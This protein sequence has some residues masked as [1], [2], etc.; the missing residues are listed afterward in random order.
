METDSFPIVGVGASAGGLEALRSMFSGNSEQCGMAFVV[1]QHLDPTHESLMAQL[2]ERYTDMTVTQASG[3]ER[4]EPDHI[5]V[6]PPGHGL[7]LN[8]GILNLTEFTEQRGMRRPI[9]DFFESLARDRHTNA[10][11]VILSGTGAD[12]SRG[13]RAIKEHGGLAIAQ[14][15]DSAA[16]DGMPSSAIS[17]GLVDIV[18][19]PADIIKALDNFFSRASTTDGFVQGSDEVA[20]NLESLCD[21]LRDNTGHDLSR[22]K[23]NTL[24]RRVARRMQL[25]GLESAREYVSRLQDDDSEC[26]AL[27]SDLLINVTRFFRDPQQFETLRK[28]VIEPLVARSTSK[29]EIRVWVPGCSSGEEAYSMAMMFADEARK[30][31]KNPFIQIFATDID[32]KMLELARAATYPLSSLDDIPS[33]M[34]DA[35]IIG[36][37]DKFTIAPAIRDMVRISEHNLV[38]DPPF[39]K[40]DLVSCRNVLIY[41][42]DSLQRSVIPLFHFALTE[43]GRLFLGSSETIGRFEDLFET[44]D[45]SARIFRRKSVQGKY[46][47]QLSSGL[48]NERKVTGRPQNRTERQHSKGP[49]IRALQIVAERYGPVSLLV[50]SEGMLL[51][52]WGSA[53]RYL[54]FPDRLERNVHVPTLARPGLRELVGP[55]I[56]K[57]RETGRRSGSRDVEIRTDF[58][59]LGTRVVCEP[60]DDNAFLLVIVETSPLDTT[61]D[62]FDEL[63]MDDGHRQFLEEELQATRHRLRTTVEELETTN[64]ELKSSNEEMMSMNE[65]LQSTNE[66][67]TTVND[68]LKSKVDEL[69]VANSDLKNFFDSTQLAVMV[70]DSKLRLR[71]FTDAVTSIFPVT[72]EQI[73]E[74]LDDLPRR[75]DS[76]AFVD[77]ARAAARRGEVQ[78]GRGRS[79]KL[80][81]EFIIRAFPYRRLNGELDG[82]TLIF[83]NVTSALTLERDL[84]EEKQRLTLALQVAKIGIWEYIPGTDETILDDTERELLNIPSG[85]D[86]AKMQPI[87][88]SIPA[89]HRDRVNRSLRQAIDGTEMFDEIFPIPLDAD[90]NGEVRWLHGLGK[91]IASDGE[92]KF[93]GVTFDITAER[94]LLEQRELMIREMNHRVKNLFAVISAMVTIASRETEDC[95]ELAQSL[96]GRIHALGRSH[97][98]T[99]QLEHNESGGISL[100]KLL[101]TVV[102]PSKA[103]QTVEFDGEDVEIPNSQITSLALILHEWATNS[104]KYGAFSVPDG[105]L[106]VGW[107]CRDDRVVLRWVETGQTT[108]DDEDA[109][110][111]FG[112]KMVSTAARQLDGHVSA[113]S[114]DDSYRLSLE[115]KLA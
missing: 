44:V 47:L 115:F 27:F 79:S 29:G 15:P 50:D 99:T 14:E 12:G 100:S 10:A 91:Q 77:F 26:H 112:T 82:A 81:E 58:G 62:D 68:E 74:E 17:T 84:K 34:R 28:E 46:S 59:T 32:D 108:D 57:S 7:A 65:E 49:E 31:R 1:V 109:A 61:S 6:I 39:S 113:R 66:E 22:Y 70:V 24:V 64:E 69:T 4:V 86:G 40:I 103:T 98:L 72:N 20:D 110:T 97:S 76:A 18:S 30:K 102:L 73:G 35:Y 23:Q 37:T 111:G 54:E 92:K 56:R 106:K 94:S 5:Y 107:S 60:L 96:R 36:G 42:N 8:D 13:L 67:L 21:I 90:G 45:Q 95:Q 2:I 83:T 11:C 88:D 53:S 114:D 48:A 41:F 78:E 51:E 101:H 38:R 104:T 75:I 43:E 19:A 63:E 55:L 25:L 71:S 52:R 105:K 89:D 80:D 93:I 16:Y 87:L 85:S 3:G 33:E 9:D